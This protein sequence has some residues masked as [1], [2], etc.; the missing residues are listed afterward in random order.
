MAD[1]GSDSD[2][3]D[4]ANYQLGAAPGGAPVP[5]A[6]S[7][8][9]DGARGSGSDSDSDWDDW[10]SSMLEAAPG[11][12]PPEAAVHAAAPEQDETA[13]TLAQA[14]AGLSALAER[15]AAATAATA[16]SNGGGSRT[17]GSAHSPRADALPAGGDYWALLAEHGARAVEASLVLPESDPVWQKMQ[18]ELSARGETPSASCLRDVAPVTS[19]SDLRVMRTWLA[20][21]LPATRHLCGALEGKGWRWWR[22]GPASHPRAVVGV[23]EDNIET[24][25]WADS[26][27]ALCEALSEALTPGVAHRTPPPSAD[28]LRLHLVDEG[29]CEILASR[30]PRSPPFLSLGTWVCSTAVA[31][32]VARWFGDASVVGQLRS[33]LTQCPPRPTLR[34]CS[35]SS[36]SALLVRVLPFLLP[37]PSQAPLAGAAHGAAAAGRRGS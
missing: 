37:A 17:P 33:C 22:C 1:S 28:H 15:H 6:A 26:R 18:Q 24:L 23:W 31:V 16:A 10:A 3:D 36:P 9:R 19:P 14:A 2:W 5:Q 29:V 25:A 21:L 8:A 12:A 20:S 32:H 27:D 11:V 30:L 4:W 13:A 34:V 35:T 7:D